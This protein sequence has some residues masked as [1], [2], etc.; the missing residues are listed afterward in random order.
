MHHKKGFSMEDTAV[1][2]AGAVN[3]L[4]MNTRYQKEDRIIL[5]VINLILFY[6]YP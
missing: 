3:Q 1:I 4:S 6:K 2:S 5:P